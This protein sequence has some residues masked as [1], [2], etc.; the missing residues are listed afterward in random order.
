MRAV[1][2]WFS[3]R[4]PKDLSIHRLHQCATALLTLR[5]YR[6]DTAQP[7][8]NIFSLVELQ[9]RDLKV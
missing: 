8:E 1:S 2:A 4:R 6:S 5:V 7:G 3:P 9:T